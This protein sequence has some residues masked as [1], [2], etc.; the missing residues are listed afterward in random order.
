MNPQTAWP[1]QPF[2]GLA[3]SALVGITIAD[4]WPS[5]SPILAVLLVGTSVIAWLSGRTIAVYAVVALSFFFF[6]GL[7]TTGTPGQQLV[8]SLGEE[9]RPITVHGAVITEPKTSGRG[10]ASFL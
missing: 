7:R 10:T 1:R 9:P 8:S 4:H 5:V 6:H 3:L 2:L